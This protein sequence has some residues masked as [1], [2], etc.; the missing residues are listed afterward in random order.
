MSHHCKGSSG[1]ADQGSVFDLV[2]EYLFGGDDEQM[3][4]VQMKQLASS[5]KLTLYR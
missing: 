2:E 5:A 3:N 1:Y 4:K